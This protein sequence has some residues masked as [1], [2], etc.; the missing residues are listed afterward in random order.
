M[1]V[2]WIAYSKRDQFELAHPLLLLPTAKGQ[3]SEAVYVYAMQQPITVTRSPRAP[4]TSM[5][6]LHRG[7]CL[8]RSGTA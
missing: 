7:E 2:A 3:S 8:R 4:L 5:F 1:R 6:C